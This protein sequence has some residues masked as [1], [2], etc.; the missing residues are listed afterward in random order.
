MACLL[1]TPPHTR[2]IGHPAL[3]VQRQQDQITE[4]NLAFWP[5][6]RYPLAWLVPG[7]F[8]HVAAFGY[9]HA[10]RTWV[11]YDVTLAGTEVYVLPD[12]QASL[13]TIADWTAGCSILN[14]AN[15]ATNIR[16]PFGGRLGFWCVPAMKH[17]LGIRSG[18]V[19]PSQLWRSC[20]QHGAKIVIDGQQSSTTTPAYPA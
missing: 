10:C 17:L 14:F 11:L 1:S 15:P 20:L 19:L 4:W 9:S 16:K 6:G 7:R 2:K 8:K 5:V 13:A 3:I 12:G 18:A